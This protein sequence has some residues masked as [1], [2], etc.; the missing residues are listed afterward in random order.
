MAQNVLIT[1]GATRIGR[2][3]SIALGMAGWDVVVHH[4]RSK[5]EA[6]EVVSAVQ[7]LGARAIAVAADFSDPNQTE[8]LKIG[9]AHV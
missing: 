7:E 3:I 4:H 1:G 6:G 8:N 9:R 2:V 5:R